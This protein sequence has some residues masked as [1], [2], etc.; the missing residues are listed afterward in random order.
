MKVNRRSF[1][2]SLAGLGLSLSALPASV[3][4]ALNTSAETTNIPDEIP[5]G[6]LFDATVFET[7]SGVVHGP[8]RLFAIVANETP[9]CPE[10]VAAISFIRTSSCA[11]L[12]YFVKHGR[13]RLTWEAPSPWY[14]II[15]PAGDSIVCSNRDVATVMYYKRLKAASP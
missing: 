7:Y 3:Q 14:E 15:I 2:E 9:E 8:A 1:I 13:S 12:L 10:E 4:A 11:T 5:Q 6:D